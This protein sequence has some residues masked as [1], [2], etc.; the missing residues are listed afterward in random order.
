MS[1][2]GLICIKS[3]GFGVWLD[4]AMM[5]GLILAVFTLD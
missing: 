4:L 1:C 2:A 5:A 3:M